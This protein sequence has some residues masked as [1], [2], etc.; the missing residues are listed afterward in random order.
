MLV[1]YK[2]NQSGQLVRQA[3]IYSEAE[4]GIEKSDIDSN[5]SYICRTLQ[6]AGY[7]TYIVGG[8]IRDLLCGIKPK[9][10]DIITAAIPSQVRKLFKQSRVIGKRFKLVHVVRDNNCYEVATFRVNSN[11][12]NVY[13]TL[14][15]DAMRRDFTINAFYYDPVD[16]RLID[17]N[18]SMQDIKKRVIEPIIPLGVIFKE[19]PVRMLRAV[20][21]SVIT[22][23]KIPSKL[24]EAIK[25]Q[26]PLLKDCSHSRLGEELLKILAS[27][28]VAEIFK[29]LYDYG[30]LKAFLPT[31]DGYIS[32]QGKAKQLFFN[33]L[34]EASLREERSRTYMLYV[35]LSGYI[36]DV[37]TLSHENF[38]QVIEIMRLALRPIALPHS[39]LLDA[40]SLIYAEAGLQLHPETEEEPRRKRNRYQQRRGGRKSS[41]AK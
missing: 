28:N 2:K 26:A 21:Y 37:A 39:D 1:R 20:K 36:K 33:G 25:E 18:N 17:F 16:G 29:E 30:L 35:L 22:G 12:R 40:A 9:D 4:H 32:R 10:F 27:P 31:F 3:N 6:K 15:E 14:D 23:R 24:R 13:G 7:E 41:K 11:E 8:A 34:A 38:N 5:A 19:D